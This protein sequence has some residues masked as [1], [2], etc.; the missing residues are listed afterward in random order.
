MPIRATNVRFQNILDAADIA[1]FASHVDVARG[2][3]GG[4]RSGVAIA[5]SYG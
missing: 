5:G 3:S 1:S 4:Y 2:R